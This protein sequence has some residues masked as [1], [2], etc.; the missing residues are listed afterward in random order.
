MSFYLAHLCDRESNGGC[1]QICNK[2]GDNVECSCNEGFK[3]SSDGVS[4]DKS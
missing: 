2:K 4:C 3:L 1:S